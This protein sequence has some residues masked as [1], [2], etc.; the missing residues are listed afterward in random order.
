MWLRL[1]PVCHHYTHEDGFP[2]AG[3]FDLF[4][5][6]VLNNFTIQKFKNTSANVFEHGVHM[7]GVGRR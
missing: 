3:N 2:L 1:K 4:F 6:N 5:T 7:A